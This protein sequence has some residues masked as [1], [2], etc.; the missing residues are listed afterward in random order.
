M[1]PAAPVCPVFTRCPAREDNEHYFCICD[2][3]CSAAGYD[4]DKDEQL[5]TAGTTAARVD[6]ILPVGGLMAELAGGHQTPLSVA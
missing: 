6:R 4:A 1:A 5:Y 3:L 2:G